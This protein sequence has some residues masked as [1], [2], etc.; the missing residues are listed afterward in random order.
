MLTLS[1]ERLEDFIIPSP[2]SFE[3]KLIATE[4]SIFVTR[5]DRHN[6]SYILYF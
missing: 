4:L 5:L 3:S 2:Y 6:Y 1:P